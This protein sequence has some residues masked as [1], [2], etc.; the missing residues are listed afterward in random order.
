[1]SEK[2]FTKMHGLGNDFMVVDL[3]DNTYK[4]NKKHIIAWSNRKTGIG[5]DQFLLLEPP[6]DK[7][8]VAR[9]RIFN[10][11]G[12]EVEQCGNGARC[13]AKYL[14]DRGHAKPGEFTVETRSSFL[15]IHYKSDD[16]ISILLG[17]PKFEDEETYEF[18][19]G[20]MPFVPVQIGN[21]HAIFYVSTHNPEH[22]KAIG[23][24]L[25]KSDRF[26]NGVNVSFAKTLT[27]DEIK[28]RTYER[29]VGLTEA[30]GTGACASMVAGLITRDL[31][32][33]V[34]AHLGL[35]DIKVE[36]RPGEPLKM[37]G[38]A[39]EVFRGSIIY[40]ED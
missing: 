12:E 28:V 19:G 32:N 27:Q 20:L 2:K 15:P 14:V 7:Q 9:Y 10:A 11:D 33:I 31:K 23:E 34:T 8:H 25:Q 16:E 39:R 37:T 21:P 40:G 13:I 26:P 5:F 29:G 24:A 30:C 17:E 22:L 38:P 3:F 4:L 18:E 36:W 35:G 6:E 1:M